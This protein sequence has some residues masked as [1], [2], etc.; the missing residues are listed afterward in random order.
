MPATDALTAAAGPVRIAM[1]S[2]PRTI[3][4]ALMRAFENRPDTV[5]IDEPLYAHYLAET[6]LDHP[7]RDEVLAAQ[8]RDWRVVVDQL[9]GRV[10]GGAGVCYQK[11][12]A[13]H[14]T[15]S[16]GRDW[17]AKVTNWFLIR[18]PRSMLASYVRSRA[19]VTLS[20]TGLPQQL[21]LFEA[22]RVRTGE[23]PAVVDSYDVLADPERLLRRLCD[24]VGIAFSDR[25]L[26][27]PV[28]SRDSDGVWAPYWYAAAE[29]STGFRTPD[30][31]EAQLPEHLEPLAAECQPYFD[32]LGQHRLR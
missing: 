19:D 21:E 23:V 2:G 7:G 6:G 17:I 3:S 32:E 18:D 5:V 14:L 31:D 1:W 13:H 4:T 30:A 8:E 9:T 11:H 10:P 15:P 27:W 26:A 24:A 22:V 28:G 12:M 29:A 20:D 25:M 16:V